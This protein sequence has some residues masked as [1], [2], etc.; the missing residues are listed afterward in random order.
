LLL[1]TIASAD[2]PLSKTAISGRMKDRYDLHRVTLNAV[3]HDVWQAWHRQK[4]DPAWTG[5]P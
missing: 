1:L 2:V 4:S 3:D 5:P